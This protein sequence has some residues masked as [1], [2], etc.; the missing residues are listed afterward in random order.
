MKRYLLGNLDGAGGACCLAGVACNA[1][2][3]VGWE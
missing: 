2:V 3:S 1:L